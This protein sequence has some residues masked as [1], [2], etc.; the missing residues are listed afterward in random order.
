MYY[1]NDENG[2]RV[3]IDSAAAEYH[4]YCPACK[5]RMIIKRGK[6][7]APHFAHKTKGQC[8]PWYTGK[9]SQW[10]RKLQ[11]KF[12][13]DMQEVIL[14]N[15]DNTEYHV[16]DVLVGTKGKG[17][18]FEF[19][20]SDISVETFISRTQFYM[21]LGCSVVW[22]F[23]Y[24]DSGHPK[25]IFYEDTVISERLKHVVWPGRDRVRI[26][27]SEIMRM[28]IEGC[29]NG[30]HHLSVLFNVN[31]GRGQEHLCEYQNG[32]QSYR[33]EFI[34]P[35]TREAYY[36]RPDFNTTESLSD[37]WAT[38]FTEEEIDEHIQKIVAKYKCVDVK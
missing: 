31:T 1:A 16:A 35:L 7:I 37:F 34:D 25:C 22:I 15:D 11:N 32:Y 4:Y 21:N 14:W 26:F 19:Q 36:I 13:P 27:D 10:H 18:V 28:F 3:N 30:E 9:M 8:D 23:D 6:I 33:W 38:F 12:S 5:S 24:Q 29:N 17:L 2:V 20:H